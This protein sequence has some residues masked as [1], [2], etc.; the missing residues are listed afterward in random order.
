MAQWLTESWFEIFQTLGIA[1]SLWYAGKALVLDRRTRRTEILLSLTEA[2]RSIWEKMIEH[3]ELS[4]ILDRGIDV[5]D[6]PPTEPETRFVKLLLLHLA[7]VH[8]AILDRAYE[9]A[10]EMED[11]VRIFLSLPIPRHVLRG[12]LPFQ[13]KSFRLY[14]ESLISDSPPVPPHSEVWSKRYPF[15][16][17]SDLLQGT[18]SSISPRNSPTAEKGEEVMH[19]IQLD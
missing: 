12:V 11:D 18:P 10:P 19:S 17:R 9:P 4:R 15:D 6:A 1:G 2:H 14:V 13:E 16:L 5:V 3:P 7:S 8:R